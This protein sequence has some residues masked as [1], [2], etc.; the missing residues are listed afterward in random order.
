MI[1]LYCERL[2]PGIWAEPI[3]ALTNLAFFLAGWLAW[4]HSSRIPEARQDRLLVLIIAT[5]PIVGVGSFVFHT[6]A[7]RWAEWVDVIPILLF[8]LLYLWLIATRFFS[9]SKP[10]SLLALLLFCA[11]TFGLE[12]V[13]PREFL[14]G[15]AMYLP[16]LAVLVTV[17]ILA[18]NLH[19]QARRSFHIAVILFLTS[20][21]MRSLDQPLCNTLPF[22]THFLWHLLNALLLYLLVRAALAQR[23][24]SG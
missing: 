13:V 23:A 24:H 22:G 4:R 20:Y 21:T 12:A 14:W 1:D 17:G 15:G 7:T 3:N 8:M 5:I 18:P 9:L 2:G 10:A 16:T 11:A 19:A 6:L